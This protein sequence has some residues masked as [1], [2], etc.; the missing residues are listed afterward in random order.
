MSMASTSRLDWSAFYARGHGRLGF[1]S[2]A[3]EVESFVR[4]VQGRGACPVV[5]DIGAGTGEI[6]GELLTAGLSVVAAE[7]DPSARHVLCS[8]YGHE[9]RCTVDARSALQLATA[10]Q[11]YDGAIAVR[12][13]NHGSAPNVARNIRSLG[14]LVKPGG[15]LLLHIAS[16]RDFRLRLARELRP[17]T[18]VPIDGPEEGIPHVFLGLEELVG[19][20]S[21]AFEVVSHRLDEKP[22]PT[23]SA[24]FA[25]YSASSRREMQD[26]GMLSSHH[27]LMA[28]RV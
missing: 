5:L 16:D 19:L 18:Y 7:P 27:V 2:F 11:D 12:S 20:L 9:P 26:K 21:G 28:V 8:T 23:G 1:S 4:L 15:P 22:V 14:S 6:T 17:D 10:G 3:S 13:I 24:Y 25:E